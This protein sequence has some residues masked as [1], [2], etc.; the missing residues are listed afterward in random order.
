MCKTSD[1]QAV[2]GGALRTLSVSLKTGYK[3]RE[4]RKVRDTKTRQTRKHRPVRAR[5]SSRYWT[6]G[7]R[8][9]ASDYY[10]QK[11]FHEMAARHIPGACRP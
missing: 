1:M 10:S 4:T 6:S 7:L 5:E 9:P 8:S 3:L 11:G 2:P